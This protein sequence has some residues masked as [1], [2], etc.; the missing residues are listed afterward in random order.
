MSHWPIEKKIAANTMILYF[1]Q[2]QLTFVR[3]ALEKRTEVVNEK[4]YSKN[5]CLRHNTQRRLTES[6][7]VRISMRFTQ[8]LMTF[9]TNDDDYFYAFPASVCAC[10]CEC[11][12]SERARVRERERENV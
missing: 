7:L 2:F 5:L 1:P 11:D 10:V 9:L 4:F 6:D 8:Q 3:L 12:D